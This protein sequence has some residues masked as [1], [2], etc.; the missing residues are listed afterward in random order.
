MT[1]SRLHLFAQVVCTAKS[2]LG[3]WVSVG[4]GRDQSGNPIQLQIIASCGGFRLV[5]GRGTLVY[6]LT[7]LA[8]YESL[9]NNF[10]G[11]PLARLSG[12]GV[13]SD[14]QFFNLVSNKICKFADEEGKKAGKLSRNIKVDLVICR[15]T[16]IS[17]G[18]QFSGAKNRFE[19]AHCFTHAFF[20]AAGPLGLAV[21]NLTAIIHGGRFT[22][23]YAFL[24]L[25]TLGCFFLPRVPLNVLAHLSL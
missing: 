22:E 2:G 23:S 19:A 6:K 20:I 1:E 8:G 9:V 13:N 11:D 10:L 18:K 17:F 16:H 12:K 14:K 5:Q 21:H 15:C 7:H 24:L 3:L 4:R 25:N